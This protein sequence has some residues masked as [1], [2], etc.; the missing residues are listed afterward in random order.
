MRYKAD[1]WMGK[2]TINTL[3]GEVIAIKYPDRW[4]AGGLISR[5]DL[6]ATLGMTVDA[7]HLIEDA[8]YCGKYEQIRL[9]PNEE[10]ADPGE[11][12][13]LITPSDE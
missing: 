11:D 6:A 9:N 5:I 13:L 7:I 1:V 4:R 8:F 12:I 10:D 2:L 3:S